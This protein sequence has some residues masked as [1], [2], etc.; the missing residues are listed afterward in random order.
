MQQMVANSTHLQPQRHRLR[1]LLQTPC[2]LGVYGYP[3]CSMRTISQW[4]LEEEIGW[5]EEKESLHDPHHHHP[6]LS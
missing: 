2:H 1:G 3:L 4:I 6:T 5:D